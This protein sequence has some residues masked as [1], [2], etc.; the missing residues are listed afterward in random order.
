MLTL[1]SRPHAV[2][3]CGLA[4]IV[5]AQ[6]PRKW[7]CSA[8]P[9]V[10]S[11]RRGR[12]R[13]GGCRRRGG[14]GLVPL[15]CFLR[16]CHGYVCSEETMTGFMASCH[17]NAFPSLHVECEGLFLVRTW[18]LLGKFLVLGLL[19]C[20][21]GLEQSGWQTRTS[22]YSSLACVR[23]LPGTSMRQLGCASIISKSSGI[24]IF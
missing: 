22:T 3:P 21:L 4:R 5:P 20:L 1:P 23:L 12:R 16:L 9:S 24:G 10:A 17:C 15:C 2:V 19:V 13:R 11:F 18:S 14:R 8:I 7:S 6:T